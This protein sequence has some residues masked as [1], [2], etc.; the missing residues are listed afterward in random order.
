MLE[1]AAVKLSI[2]PHP[3]LNYGSLCK[4]LFFRLQAYGSQRPS[5]IEGLFKTMKTEMAI[6]EASQDTL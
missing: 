4:C 1:L 2:T 6:G 3:V 5:P